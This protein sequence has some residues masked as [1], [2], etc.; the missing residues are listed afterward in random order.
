MSD[1]TEREA[2]EKALRVFLLGIEDVL[3]KAGLA[4]ALRQANVP[5][6]ISHYPPPTMDRTGH[7]A[8]YIT[9]VTRA[10][11]YEGL[12]LAPLKA[13]VLWVVGAAKSGGKLW[14]LS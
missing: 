8:R 2:T 5:Q 6:Y 7:Q 3:G 9:Q 4:T 10:I 1:P 11:E 14:A 12:L 13:R